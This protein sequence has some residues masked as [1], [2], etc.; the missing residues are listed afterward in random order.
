MKNVRQI[1]AESEEKVEVRIAGEL[2]SLRKSRLIAERNLYRYLGRLVEPDVVVDESE[3][4]MLL[5][6][7]SSLL[8]LNI[9]ITPTFE[10]RRDLVPIAKWVNTL[11]D[12]QEL[13]PELDTM[14]TAEEIWDTFNE[15]ERGIV[16]WIYYQYIN[17]RAN[18]PHAGL[19]GVEWMV[20]KDLDN[21][22][23][24]FHRWLVKIVHENLDRTPIVAIYRSG[25]Y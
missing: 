3:E 23:C 1:L 13:S 22:A 11:R 10:F 2:D 16:I 18:G 15:R 8:P 24:T 21:Y 14:M 12:R 4:L 25:S 6:K 20:E 19:C 5:E 9:D 7:C 17:A